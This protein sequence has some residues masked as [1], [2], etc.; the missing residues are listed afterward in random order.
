MSNDT[1]RCLEMSTD[2]YVCKYVPRGV[3][4]K[5]SRVEVSRG[6]VGLYSKEH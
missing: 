1:K 5:A 4:A 3:H 2:V 6:F